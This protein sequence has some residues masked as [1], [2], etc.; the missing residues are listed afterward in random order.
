MYSAH[1]SMSTPDDRQSPKYITLKPMSETSVPS[2]PSMGLMPL[3]GYPKNG[4]YRQIP[5]ELAQNSQIYQPARHMVDSQLYP[6]QL[7]SGYPQ[8]GYGPPSE[9]H[10]GGLSHLN[11]DHNVSTTS[12]SPSDVPLV[13]TSPSYPSTQMSKASVYLCNRDLWTRFHAHTTEMIITKQGR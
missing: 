9:I 1:P 10:H 5:A 8:Q 7:H 3:V 4:Q 2:G 11:T 6:D 13:G 12:L